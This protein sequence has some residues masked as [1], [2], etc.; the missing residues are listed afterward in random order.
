MKGQKWHMPERSQNKVASLADKKVLKF[1]YQ[2][3]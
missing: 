2:N 3:Y 1:T